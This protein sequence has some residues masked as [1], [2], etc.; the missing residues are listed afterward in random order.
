MKLGIHFWGG[1]SVEGRA[2][3][4]FSNEERWPERIFL[5]DNIKKLLFTRHL[6]KT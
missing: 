2:T 4:W 5:S 6:N 1:G 3:F